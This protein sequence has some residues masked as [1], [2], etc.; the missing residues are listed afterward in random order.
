MFFGAHCQLSHLVN[1]K[2]NNLLYTQVCLCVC[3]CVGVSVCACVQ[4]LQLMIYLCHLQYSVECL[5]DCF[6]HSQ[7]VLCSFPLLHLAI[8]TVSFSFYNFEICFPFL[9]DLF[10]SFFLSPSSLWV[11]IFSYLHEEICE[12]FEKTKRETMLNITNGKAEFN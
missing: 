9:L 12:S 11:S 5:N 6:L 2:L 8:A 7:N 4:F 10:V 1:L 3:V